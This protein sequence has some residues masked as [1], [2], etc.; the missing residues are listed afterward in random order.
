MLANV[1]V[2][3][4]RMPTEGVPIVH[5]SNL[6]LV[7]RRWCSDGRLVGFYMCVNWSSRKDMC[8]RIVDRRAACVVPEHRWHFETTFSHAAWYARGTAGDGRP[9]LLKRA[10]WVHCS[11]SFGT[12]AAEP[13]HVRLG[14]KSPHS[15]R[16]GSRRRPAQTWPNPFQ[17]VSNSGDFWPNPPRFGDDTAPH[18]VGTNPRATPGLA[19]AS[20]TLVQH[21][22]DP[23]TGGSPSVIWQGSVSKQRLRFCS[24]AQAK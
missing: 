20:S 14:C 3:Y 11:R 18:S 7:C 19:E 15:S 24:V 17:H 22:L 12:H 16:L 6:A 13:P 4:K 2:V 21:L 8:V 23:S 1:C 9:P 10:H 5:R